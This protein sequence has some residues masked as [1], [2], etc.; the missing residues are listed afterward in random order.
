MGAVTLILTSQTQF[1]LSARF[2]CNPPPPESN[3]FETPVETSTNMKPNLR[4][5][6]LFLLVFRQEFFP[7][8][9][10][11]CVRVCMRAPCIIRFAAFRQCG[12]EDYLHFLKQMLIASTFLRPLLHLRRDESH[13]I[14]NTLG[15]YLHR[16]GTGSKPCF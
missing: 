9:I 5:T 4:A 8:C 3:S 6:L 7:A 13:S 16:P 12:L 15:C 11:E 1:L 10:P 14:L 2:L